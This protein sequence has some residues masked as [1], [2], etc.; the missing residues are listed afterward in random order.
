MTRKAVFAMFVTGALITGS[1]SA[2]C[3]AGEME[4]AESTEV[5]TGEYYFGVLNIP[6]ADFYYGEINHIKPESLEEG[7]AGKYD[8]ED[9]VSM[10]GYREDGIYDAVT[11]ATNAKSTRFERTYYEENGDGAEI[12]G[13]SGVNVAIPKLLYEDVQK[14]IAEGKECRNPLIDFVSALGEVTEEIPAEYKVILSDGTLSETIGTVVPAENVT[15]DFATTS[16][17]GNY[18]ISLE[19][20]ELDAAAIQGALLETSDGSIYGLEHLDNLW[21]QPQEVA[22]AV[23]E[24]TE[25]HG[26]TPSYQR[27]ESIQGKTITKLTYMLAD[28]DDISIDLDFYCKEL[29]P[30]KYSVFVPETAV[31]SREGTKLEV[32]ANVPEGSDYV[33]DSVLAGRAAVEDISLYSME[34]GVI[35]LSPELKPGQYSVVLSDETY[36]DQKLTCMVT[37]GWN[38]GDVILEENRLVVPENE[39]GLTA[40]DYISSISSVRIN[41]EPVNGRDLGKVIFMEDGTINPDAEMDADGEQ[42]PVFDGIDSCEI[43]LEAAGY[44]A[45]AG[46]ITLP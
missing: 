34:D 6:Y 16:V 44:P 37:A 39:N 14:A 35:T 5:E 3:M 13:P 15:A 45:V 8:A 7:S 26:N 20:L 9:I 46:T 28:E 41:G 40:A 30:E 25:P 11:S 42:V 22:F 4:K 1:L 23:T 12:Y 43:A 24:M 18:Q 2:A 21:L 27:F 31:Y 36:A 33:L 29:L 17:W 10:A 38:D 19:G 32:T